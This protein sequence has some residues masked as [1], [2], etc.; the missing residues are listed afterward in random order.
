M[1]YANKNDF[2]SIWISERHVDNF[3]GLYPNPAVIASS[4]AAVTKNINL[5]KRNLFFLSFKKGIKMTII[6]YVE[7]PK[8][9]VHL[10]K[11]NHLYN[12]LSKCEYEYITKFRIKRDQIRS[13]IGTYM[14][15]QIY[16]KDNKE[17]EVIRKKRKKPYVYIGIHKES[18][19][20]IAHSKNMIIVAVSDSNIGVDIEE[21]N[22]NSYI[23]SL[24]TQRFV[25]DKVNN[26]ILN[27][28]LR[29]SYGKM[30]GEGLLSK[31]LFEKNFTRI[32]ANKFLIDDKLLSVFFFK[33]QYL[34]SVCSGFETKIEIK[35]FKCELQDRYF[36]Q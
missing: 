10:N 16:K 7:L 6:Y 13:L 11:Y 21:I 34:I 9:D 18:N 23:P 8:E 3:R 12:F 17:I 27:W 14:L 36:F 29:E 33:E 19:F 22:K 28:V 31:D 32:G 35:K 20:N 2:S 1:K 30:I 15:K 24:K 5:R 25:E 26:F 4:I